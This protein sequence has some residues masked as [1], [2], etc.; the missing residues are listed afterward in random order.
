MTT[1][2]DLKIRHT[3]VRPPNQQG[4]AT[5][6][7]LQRN[8]ETAFWILLGSALAYYLRPDQVV[9]ANTHSVWFYLSL[10]SLCAFFSV[11]TYLELYLPRKQ[12]VRV[13]YKRWETEAPRSIQL[14]TVFG[15]YLAVLSHTP[16]HFGSALRS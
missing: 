13:N 7:K 6:S 3:T 15:Y 9:M 12:G 14:A 10:L 5:S 8:L 1:D 11:F 4:S 16:P 2:A